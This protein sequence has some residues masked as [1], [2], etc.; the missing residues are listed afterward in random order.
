MNSC[1]E[2]VAVQESTGPMAGYP[3]ENEDHDA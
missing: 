3:S 2:V 1:K